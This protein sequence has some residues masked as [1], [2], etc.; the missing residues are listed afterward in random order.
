[1]DDKARG[2]ERFEAWLET[3][4][5]LKKR[6]AVD[7]AAHDAYESGLC[8]VVVGYDGRGAPIRCL[9]ETAFVEGVVKVADYEIIEDYGGGLYY[10]HSPPGVDFLREAYEDVLWGGDG[11][12]AE[13]NKRN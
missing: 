2:R 9:A 11:L 7:V 3:L 12:N 5:E 4:P 1:D 6:A 13:S 8:P 10:V